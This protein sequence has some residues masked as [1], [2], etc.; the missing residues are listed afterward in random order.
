MATIKIDNN[1]YEVESLSEESKS[2]L[3]SLQYVDSELSKLQKKAAV[4]QT[5]RIAYGRAL[6]QTLEDGKIP[7]EKEVS[8]EG[9]GENIEFE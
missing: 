4:L 6:R 9:L 5:A 8:L 2:Q 3:A 7:E 1:E